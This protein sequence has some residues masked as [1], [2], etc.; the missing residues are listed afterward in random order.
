MIHL[1]KLL[2]C[3]KRK[4]NIIRCQ[5]FSKTN[6]EGRISLTSSVASFHFLWLPSKLCP[7]DIF[8]I[9]TCEVSNYALLSSLSKLFLS[10]LVWI[11]HCLYQILRKG[12]NTCSLPRE[13]KQTDADNVELT[14]LTLDMEDSRI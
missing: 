12:L 3:N 2:T 8:V 10:C 1:H 4:K 9:F 5:C 7:H 11:L 13:H 14:V 6:L